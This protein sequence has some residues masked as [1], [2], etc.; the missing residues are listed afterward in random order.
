MAVR[1][2]IRWY[3]VSIHLPRVLSKPLLTKLHPTVSVAVKFT[4]IHSSFTAFIPTHYFAYMRE[5]QFIITL[6]PIQGLLQSL[7]GHSY[8]VLRA[9][10]WR[11]DTFTGFNVMAGGN[12]GCSDH[13][14]VELKILCGRRK[15]ISRIA[16]PGFRR[17]S[18]DF[19]E[20]LLG[21]ITWAS[22]GR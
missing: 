17:D 6:H 11:T 8:S 16:T 2:N 12:L 5:F 13:K 21:G 3:T 4:T 7:V 10:T 9:P 22:V 19:F 1:L 18:F 15:V 20:D 14:M